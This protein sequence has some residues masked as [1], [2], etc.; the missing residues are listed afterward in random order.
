MK[1]RLPDLAIACLLI[2]GFSFSLVQ[3]QQRG[4][5]QA[6][7]PRLGFRVAPPTYQQSCGTC[8]GTD[9][10]GLGPVPPLAGRSPSYTVRQL[11]DLQR[12][13]RRGP[14]SPLMAE[15][16]KDLTVDDLIAIAAYTA[17]REP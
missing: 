2:V 4:A 7:P 15:A 12:G 1:T 14:W 8:H 16:V 5:A 3:A 9:L 13:V 6:G 11:Y 10:K 17:S